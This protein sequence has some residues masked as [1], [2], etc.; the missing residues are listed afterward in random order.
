M[1]S[2]PQPSRRSVLAA[3]AAAVAAAVAR[4]LDRPLPVR[5]AGSDGAN[6]T[7]GGF[8]AD[9]QSQ[10]TLA[11]QANGERVLWVASNADLGHGDG[12]AITGYSNKSTGVEGWSEGAASSG[13][14]GHASAFGVKGEGIYGTY[15]TSADAAGA[16]S[17]GYNLAGGVGAYGNGGTGVQGSSAAPTGVGVVGLALGNGTG[18]H[19]LSGPSG[20]VPPAKTGVYGQA[21]QDSTSVGVKGH[22][23][24]GHGVAGSATSGRAVAGSATS[25]IGLYGASSSGYAV[26]TS[27]RV[28]FDKASGVATIA[29]GATTV[30]V[31]ATIDITTSTFVLLTPMGN[32]AGS[33][34]WVTLDA[35]NNQFT[36]HLGAAPATSKKVG[37]LIVG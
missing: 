7:V 33:S 13:V 32:L 1:S 17:Y 12:I 27:G 11:N 9:A 10:T 29:G 4:A 31:T 3:A 5:A 25:G 19:G 36:I 20:T 16:G 34:M 21:T 15:G 23:T 35:T 18:L 26:R 24:S 6:I 14:Y 30:T 8:Y 2:I 28:R 37:W 22:S